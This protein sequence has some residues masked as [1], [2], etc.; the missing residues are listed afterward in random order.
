MGCSCVFGRGGG[1][2]AP[3]SACRTIRCVRRGTS[4]NGWRPTVSV[5]GSA[6]AM[7]RRLRDRRALVGARGRSRRGQLGDLLALGGM[8]RRRTAGFP[9]SGLTRHA[10][11]RGGDARRRLRPGRPRRHV[12]GV[13]RLL[14]PPSRCGRDSGVVGTAWRDPKFDQNVT[15]VIAGASVAHGRHSG[16]GV[17][18]EILRGPRQAGSHGEPAHR[19]EGGASH[20]RRHQSPV[21]GGMR[22]PIAPVPPGGTHEVLSPIRDGGR[23]RPDVELHHRGVSGCRDRG[24]FLEHARHLSVARRGIV[25]VDEPAG[26][27]IGRASVQRQP[28]H[29]DHGIVR[30]AH[31]VTSSRASS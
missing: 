11:A 19:N 7:T 24:E 23:E 25:G 13:R 26:Q 17:M 22:G 1:G 29:L 3:G 6:P 18:N 4:R 9:P 2:T 16:Q 30:R 10:N 20:Q 31:F 21:A 5:P 12:R 27:P 14:R 8:R 28:S 15:G